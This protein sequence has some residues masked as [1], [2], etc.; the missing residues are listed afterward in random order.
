ML[1]GRWSDARNSCSA[2]Y[3][4]LPPNS[5]AVCGAGGAGDN[6]EDWTIAPPS[7]NHPGGVGCATCD[8]S[9]RF[10]SD[11]VNTVNAGVPRKSGYENV[12]GLNLA[13][14]FLQGAP[15]N[16]PEYYTGQSP[17]GVWGAYGTPH[18]GDNASF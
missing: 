2:V 4:I 15:D 11:S 18:H 9:Y 1:G 13:F 8:G 12:S 16:N 3:T 10:V 17:Y 6:P 14:D 5:P 7:S